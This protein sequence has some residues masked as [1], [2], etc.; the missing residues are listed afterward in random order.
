[1]MGQST[2]VQGIVQGGGNLWAKWLVL[3]NEPDTGI[4]EKRS[5]PVPGFINDIVWYHEVS[6]LECRVDN[7]R[8]GPGDDP[9][10]PALFQRMDVGAVIDKR[11]RQ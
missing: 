1:M 2:Q 11:G 6:R 7:S 4:L 3:A 10:D 5:L 9:L 8:T